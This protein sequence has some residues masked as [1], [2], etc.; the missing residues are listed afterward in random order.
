M[1]AIEDHH[2]YGL[3]I[4]ES[5][6][7]GSDFTNPDTDYRIAFLG[8]DG[9]WHFKDSAGTVTSPAGVGDILDLPTAETDDTLVLAPDGAGGVEFR[10]EAG[11]GA[12]GLVLLDTWDASAASSHDFALPTTY[13]EFEL[14]V[15]NLRPANNNV[16]LKA[17]FSTDGGST[18]D[19]TAAHYA[20]SSHGIHSAGT[21]TNG[22]QSDSKMLL[23]SWGETT[24]DS[25]QSVFGR[26]WISAGTASIKAKLSGLV[27][28]NYDGTSYP[29]EGET[30]FAT[31]QVAGIVNAIRL[32]ASDG[33][34]MTG[35]FRLYAW[36]KA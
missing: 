10:A 8:E 3:Q 21:G 9:V 20:Y 5:A 14:H 13:D 25:A 33:G 18:F 32:S 26:W 28:R 31:Y 35:S 34:N 12:A 29:S 24:G 27:N 1:A 11:G 22:S 16:A 23:H 6:N 15:V 17:L 19:S 36:A 2:I 30:I 7:D 4:R